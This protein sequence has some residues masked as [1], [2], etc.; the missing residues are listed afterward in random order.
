MQWRAFVSERGPL[1]PHLRLELLT[2]LVFHAAPPKNEHG[3]HLKFSDIYP[4]L[5]KPEDS[6]VTPESVMAALT[7]G[8]K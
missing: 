1:S 2:K 5:R 8:K 3:Q 4:W 7:K 6:D